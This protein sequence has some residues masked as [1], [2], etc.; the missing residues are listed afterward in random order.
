MK[1]CGPLFV[2]QAAS[3]EQRNEDATSNANETTNLLLCNENQNM[4]S[5]LPFLFL[6]KG[7]A[8]VYRV[9]DSTTRRPNLMFCVR[10]C[11]SIVY[12]DRP[13]ARHYSTTYSYS[14]AFPVGVRTLLPHLSYL[15]WTLSYISTHLLRSLN[16]IFSHLSCETIFGSLRTSKTSAGELPRTVQQEQPLQDGGRNTT[17]CFRTPAA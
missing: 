8:T 17:M 4:T 5:F 16:G 2:E 10:I 13:P 9:V 3:L 12:V 1:G 11:V 7:R 15:L 6:L 14:S